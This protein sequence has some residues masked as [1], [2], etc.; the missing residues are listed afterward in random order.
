[1]AV[2]KVSLCVWRLELA[3][4]QNVSAFN[5]QQ[6]PDEEES[7]L[8][9]RKK[10]PADIDTI[11]LHRGVRTK[12]HLIVESYDLA[13]IAD[14]DAEDAM[15]RSFISGNPEVEVTEGIL[16]LYKEN[17]LTPAPS[18]GD[19]GRSMMICML[20]VPAVLTSRDLM[21][22]L[23]PCSPE[24]QLVRIVR[25]RT[26]NQ[27]MVLLKFR[28]Q[29]GA[30]EFYKT[31]NGMPFNSLEPD[32]CHLVYVS[33]VESVKESEG[34]GLPLEF[35]TELP[36]CSVCLERMDESV[37]GVLTILCNHS[38]H[39]ACLSQWG[40]G[41]C[42]VCRYT[43]T[44]EVVE[45]SCCFSC[46]STSD[47][48]ICLICGNVGCGRYDNK[49]AEAHFCETNHIYAM[50]IGT[51]RVWDY[52]GD[53]FVHRL[54]QNKTDGKLVEL[55]GHE[56]G[57]G[58]ARVW[59][60]GSESSEEKVESMQLEYT[61]LLTSQLESQ[62]RYFEAKLE[63]VD[64]QMRKE[65]QDLKDHTAELTS[66]NRT[67]SDNVATIVA[68]KKTA[69]KKN[70]SLTARVA[71]LTQELADEK[72]LTSCLL[73]DKA[74]L[75]SKLESLKRDS[76]KQAEEITELRE[77]LRDFMFH[78]EGSKKIADE[79]QAGELQGGQVIMPEN[80]MSACG[81]RG[82]RRRNRH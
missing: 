8:L 16:H 4:D 32:L 7:L 23:A 20:A 37:D 45:R 48:W 80:E 73:S 62:R 68:E 39:S 65:L 50:Q 60:K 35:H 30:D 11:R 82:R 75:A 3:D 13:N 77:Q 12:R 47:L 53:N 59:V 61:Y 21:N 15:K 54:V 24:I 58:S 55:D 17:V 31:F 44:P 26:P 38:F 78:L 5:F 10:K 1:M 74:D 49:H 36:V 19:E 67:V 63:K 9:A 81:A 56:A 34:G 66:L 25:D 33:R 51:N 79:D 18:D 69:D 71:K 28:S 40:D 22:F 72:Q 41:S 43:S 2:A 46:P 27:Y 64:E 14:G 76:N 57:E 42:P 70:A 6:N 29:Q 52:A